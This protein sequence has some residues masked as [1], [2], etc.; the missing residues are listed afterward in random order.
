MR[1]THR[2]VQCVAVKGLAYCTVSLVEMIKWWCDLHARTAFVSTFIRR[3]WIGGEGSAVGGGGGAIKT[4]PCAA[5]Y[6]VICYI[7]LALEWQLNE[8]P[9]GRKG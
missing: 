5:L 9:Q 3:N 1:S 7:L 8:Q 6:G 2:S 4:L